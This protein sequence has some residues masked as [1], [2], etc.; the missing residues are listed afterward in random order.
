MAGS[1]E[2]RGK[3]RRL[4]A[5]GWGWSSTGGVLGGRMIKRSDDAMCGLYHAQ[6]DEEREFLGLASKLRLTVSPGFV[7]KLVAMVSWFGPENQGRWFGDLGFKI[8]TS[9]F[10]VCASKPCGRRFVA[11]RLKTD[12][13]MKMV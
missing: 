1:N 9:V 4:G 2:D 10:L 11:S 3:S 7:S 13:R 5:E 12:E 6:G 8:T